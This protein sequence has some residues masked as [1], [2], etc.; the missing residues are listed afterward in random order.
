MINNCLNFKIYF[1]T[2]FKILT[3]KGLK[4]SFKKIAEIGEI[5]ALPIIEFGETVGEIGA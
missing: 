2:S 4:R 3:F 1:I 5:G